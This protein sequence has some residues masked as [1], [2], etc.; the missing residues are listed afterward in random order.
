MTILSMLLCL[1]L[2]IGFFYYQAKAAAVGVSITPLKYDLSA[3]PGEIIHKV[4]TAI[5]PNDFPIY[6]LP[7]FQDFKLEE[8]G[9]TFIP[10][11]VDNPWKMS[12]WINIQ[13]EPILLQPKEY[14]DVPFSITIPQN[15]GAGGHYA[16]VFFKV[17]DQ[18]GGQGFGAT[19]RVGALILLNVLGEIHKTGE[20][21]EFKTPFF[22]NKGPVIL[23]SRFK[24]TGTAHYDI[25]AKVKIYNFLGFKTDEVLSETRFITPQLIRHL[26]ATWEKTWPIGIFK[27]TATISDGEGKEYSKTAWFIGFPYIWA[28]IVLGALIGLFLIFKILTK[29][30]KFKIKI[31]KG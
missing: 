16:A 8:N 31:V 2:G 24:N 12:D 3:N 15:A 11:G 30:F 27:A 26:K 9:I 29:K 4:V 1:N 7:E 17:V 20:F 22:Y 25:Q 28:S 23:E 6:V 14:H 21:L 10:P 5:N 13:T 18:G 19:A